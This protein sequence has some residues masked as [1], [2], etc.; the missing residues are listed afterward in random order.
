MKSI[1]NS[2][3]GVSAWTVSIVNLVASLVTGFLVEGFITPIGVWGSLPRPPHEIPLYWLG[4]FSSG[5]LLGFILPRMA[6]LHPV[7]LF[8]GQTLESW[9]LLYVLGPFPNQVFLYMIYLPVPT[10]GVMLGWLIRKQVKRMS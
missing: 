7:G 6:W 10:C 9:L 5:F 8:V 1:Q 3:I 2:L 4:M